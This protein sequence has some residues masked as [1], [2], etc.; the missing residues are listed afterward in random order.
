MPIDVL[1]IV[2]N[3][4]ENQANQEDICIICQDSL[5]QDNNP[6]YKLP[7]CKCVYHTNCIVTWFRSGSNRCPHCGHR[8]INHLSDERRSNKF[9]WF[10]RRFSYR[11]HILFKEF[12]KHSRKE[13]AP[14]ILKKAFEKFDRQLLYLKSVN[15]DFTEFNKLLKEEP[16]DYYEAC[17]KKRM[18]Y[19]KRWN[20]R[21]TLA[22]KFS[23]IL[24]LP[25]YPIILP[26]TIE[27]P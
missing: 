16:M 5:V 25:V 18:L 1:N 7:E 24:D 6:T 19:T 2:S 17:K 20:A 27:M 23:Q 22:N 13:D 3:N 11:D 12:K 21:H 15:K 10:G 9:H 26:Q 14:V 8:G 4:Q